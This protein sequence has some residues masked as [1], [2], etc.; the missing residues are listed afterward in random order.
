MY[1]T[2]VSRCESGVRTPTAA[3]HITGL[4]MRYRNVVA[5]DHVDLTVPPGSITSILGPNGAGKTTTIETCEGF[6]RPQEGSVRIL[7]L[8][9]IADA[10]QLRPRVGVMLQSGGAWSGIRAH[11]MLH[12]MASLYA[13]P[14]PVDDLLAKLGMTGLTRTPFR[15][16]SGGQQQ[17]L[18]LAMAI[19]GRPEL[20]FLDEPTAGLDPQAR[21]VTWE[22]IRE[23]RDRG[24]TIVLTTHFMD[25]AETLSDIV[26]IIDRGRVIASGHPAELGTARSGNTVRFSAVAGLDTSGLRAA[27]PSDTVVDEPAPGS[28]RVLGDVSPELLTTLTQW[29]A[30]IDVLPE[31]I[32]VERQT[33]EDAFLELTGRS[34]R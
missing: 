31:S 22:L 1:T 23:L 20:V 24:V 4:H 7:G 27:L 9:P 34:L 21:H 28:Y 26:Y 30:S 13:H 29:C 11:E 6:R 3:V 14:L 12:H 33:L 8:D 10:T 25:E 19:V 15:R 2:G 32:L 16:L 17:R 5:V 18:G